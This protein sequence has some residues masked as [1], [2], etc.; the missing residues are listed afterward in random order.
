MPQEPFNSKLDIDFSGYKYA[1][2]WLGSRA[3]LL[4]SGT[5]VLWI[6]ILYTTALISFGELLIRLAIVTPCL[7]SAW[8]LNNLMR[9]QSDFDLGRAML[10]IK[11]GFAV[12]SILVFFVSAVLGIYLYLSNPTPERWRDL[13][14]MSVSALPWLTAGIVILTVRK[15]RY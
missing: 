15:S 12:F 4:G 11:K 6:V 13:L 8:M 1:L 2:M 3:L 5:A 7:G 9:Q 10:T 14:L